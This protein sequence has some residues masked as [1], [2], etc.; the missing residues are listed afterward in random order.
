MMLGI[1]TQSFTSR[2]PFSLMSVQINVEPIRENR[3]VPSHG[4]ATERQANHSRSEGDDFRPQFSALCEQ[5]PAFFLWISHFECMIS[6]Q[7]AQKKQNVR[8]TRSGRESGAGGRGKAT[9]RS[10]IS[11][12]PT[13]PNLMCNSRSDGGGFSSSISAL[14]ERRSAFLLRISHFE[15]MDSIQTEQKKQNRAKR[16]APR[17]WGARSGRKPLNMHHGK[18]PDARKAST[19]LRFLPA[20]GFRLLATGFMLPICKANFTIPRLALAQCWGIL[21]PEISWNF[22]L[23]FRT[24][25][26]ANPTISAVSGPVGWASRFNFPFILLVFSIG[27]PV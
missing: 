18:R 10:I 26:V 13:T 24:L 16:A 19:A 7:T 15:C 3:S 5:H 6:I 12:P 25:T 20:P 22:T 4:S 17:S 27:I 14:Y 23:W 21:T 11:E 1:L 2:R 9:G 8:L